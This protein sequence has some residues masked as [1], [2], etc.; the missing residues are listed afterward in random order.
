MAFSPG[1]PY[2]I[3]GAL[4]DARGSSFVGREEI[5]EFVQSAMASTHRVPILL[6]GQRR[7]GKSSVLR[8]LPR[9]LPED[10][11][12]VNF[13][14]QGKGSMELDQVL[15]GLARAITEQ[16]ELPKPTR[17]QTTETTFADEFLSPL[18]VSRGLRARQIVLLFDEFDVVDE[19]I[20]TTQIAATRFIP[21]LGELSKRQPDIGYIL[22]VGRKTEELSQELN[23]S[24]LKDAVQ[25][26]IGRLSEKETARLIREPS[27]EYLRFPGEAVE[28]IFELTAGHPYCTQVLCHAIWSRHFRNAPS[29]EVRIEEV[30]AALSDALELGMLGM[31]WI[32]D[33]M[34]NPVHR[35][36]LSAMA[37][38]TNPS[39]QN[40]VYLGGIEDVMRG[41][42]ISADRLQLDLAPRD[43]EKWDV[44]RRVEGGFGFA[45]PLVGLWIRRER[46]L[47]QLER[48]VRF[49][50]P[51]AYSYFDLARE[52]H[53]QGDLD[54]AIGEY[55]SAV[56]ENRTFLEA[57]QGLA[58]ALAARR[59]PGD[60]AAAIE[61]R[62]RVLELEPN[63]PR[64]ELLELLT[65]SMNAGET[66]VEQIATRFER[67]KELDRDKQFVTRAHR[68]LLDRGYR[69]FGKG[70]A[71]DLK[72]AAVLLR[73]AEERAGA[74]AALA[75]F[76]RQRYL[77]I[78]IAIVGIGALLAIVFA[79]NGWL[80]GLT[81][82]QKLA[83]AVV[84]GASVTS[85]FVAEA[86]RFR[87]VLIAL[88]T[89]ALISFVPFA[90]WSPTTMGL[91]RYVFAG[92]MA[93]FL[94]P[95]VPAFISGF[96]SAFKASY[97]KARNR[98]LAPPK[99]PEQPQS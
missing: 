37:T 61:T 94:T 38:I 12:C 81:S 87:S 4:A 48:D 15:F 43:L 96:V 7:I 74:Q 92:V 16:L 88:A 83:C 77:Q 20:A 64:A 51:R 63:T 80:I 53:K 98:K 52:T 57:L 67:I 99:S 78:G 41:R 10:Y 33:G 14:L 89:G 13:D 45:V 71:G 11:L 29:G 42:R 66:P 25:K 69:A 23:S 62:E 8:Q 76:K 9:F 85:L 72:N 22:V 91:K 50:N 79:E 27:Q 97:A 60:L 6:F 40:H 65:D 75:A 54:R 56:Q 31:N 59:K 58:T 30:D 24:I 18:L 35:L 1:N 55:Q 68:I 36:F 93:S 3:G 70:G 5:F 28:R 2:A 86:A 49:A 82:L 17:E 39:K 21:Y 34:T 95:I 84:L 73:S 19:R 26:R 47:E 32:F 90:L 44:I 46:P